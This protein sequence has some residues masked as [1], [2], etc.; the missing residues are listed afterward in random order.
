MKNILEHESDMNLDASDMF[1]LNN[2]YNKKII[3]ITLHVT[4]CVCN[5][6]KIRIRIIIDSIPYVVS[7]NFFINK[8]PSKIQVNSNWFIFVRY[9]SL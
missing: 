6:L 9:R 2:F 7:G 4:L 1:V 8:T 3:V 5:L